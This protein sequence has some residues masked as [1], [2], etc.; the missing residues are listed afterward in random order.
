LNS[1]NTITI[2]SYSIV[3]G[4][5]GWTMSIGSYTI[6]EF[7]KQMWATQTGDGRARVRPKIR[8]IGCR[9]CYRHKLL[10]KGNASSDQTPRRCIHRKCEGRMGHLSRGKIKDLFVGKRRTM[11]ADCRNV[12]ISN[13]R[14]GRRVIHSKFDSA[15]IEE[16]ETFAHEM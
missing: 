4:T 12:P 1:R 9:E 16:S 10:M 2:H 11:G 5:R 3:H 8:L 6:W 14:A 7:T 15:E 13:Y